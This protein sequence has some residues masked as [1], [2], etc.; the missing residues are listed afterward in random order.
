MVDSY[1]CSVTV[2]GFRTIFLI[3]EFIVI[4]IINSGADGEF[5][6]PSRMALGQ[7]HPVSCCKAAAPQRSVSVICLDTPVAFGGVVEVCCSEVRSHEE[8]VRL[9]EPLAQFRLYGKC[10]EFQF[11]AEVVHRRVVDRELKRKM[12]RNVDFD[13]DIGYEHRPSDGIGLNV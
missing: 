10:P 5:D 13:C 11:A 6:I 1:E 4:D 9:A 2:G 3:V 7:R 8:A 12:R